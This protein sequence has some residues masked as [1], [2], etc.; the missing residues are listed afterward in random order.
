MASGLMSLFAQ[1][2]NQQVIGEVLRSIGLL[3]QLYEQFLATDDQTVVSLPGK[4]YCRVIS[5][6]LFNHVSDFYGAHSSQ[7]PEQAQLHS[8]P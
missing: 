5:H 8:L 3:P 4:N 7:Q 6:P 2:M 1:R